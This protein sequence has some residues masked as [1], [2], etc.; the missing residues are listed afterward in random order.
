VFAGASGTGPGGGTAASSGAGGTTGQPVAAIQV[1]ASTDGFHSCALLTTGAVRCWGYGVNG[2]LGHG[3]TA[4]IGDNEP[5]SAGGDVPLGA[6]ATQIATG[7]GHTCALLT[8]GAVRCWGWAYGGRLGYGPGSNIGDDETPA[9][10]GDVPLGATAVQIAAGGDHTCAVL[11][12]GAVRCWGLG[13]LGALGRGS[14]VSIGDDEPASAGGDVPLGA[15]AVQVTTGWSQTCALLTTGAVRCWGSVYLGNIGYG[16]LAPVIVGDDETPASVGDVPLGARAV[17]VAAGN[18]QTCALLETGA[19]RCWGRGEHGALGHGDTQDIGD[20]E[21]PASA[22]D[23]PLGATAVQIA[24][25]GMHACARLTTGAVRCWGEGSL[26]ALGYG[27]TDR[28][29]DDETPASAGDVPLGATAGHL[30]AGG[31]HTCAVLTTGAVRCWGETKHGPLGYGTFDRIGDDE[32][33]AS[34]GDVPLF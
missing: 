7:H 24:V 25:G 23:V 5:A 26:G 9:S 10:V 32:T 29:G 28:I 27:N 18:E 34:V 13:D 20:D 8:T 2:T 12:T 1:A 3:N 14:A 33:P 11:T 31:T 15:T 6:P 4:I 19:V 16:A 22:G 30:A 17:Q 21:T